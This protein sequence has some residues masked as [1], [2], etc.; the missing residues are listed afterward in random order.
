MER[1]GFGIEVEDQ[2]RLNV[3]II[4]SISDLALA[5]SR[6]VSALSYAEKIE[7]L[8]NMMEEM[9][10]KSRDNSSILFTMLQD[11]EKKFEK[12]INEVK[13]ELV[14]KIDEVKA[15]GSLSEQPSIALPLAAYGSEKVVPLPGFVIKTRKLLGNK[16][17][18]FI[19]VF[20]HDHVE[21]EPG[22]IP[23]GKANDK[24]Y[25]IACD[26]A[27]STTDK[28]GLVSLLYN[29]VVSAEY[30]KQPNDH[31]EMK[32]TSPASIQKVRQKTYLSCLL[33][34]YFHKQ[35]LTLFHFFGFDSKT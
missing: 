22:T 16:E 18:A 15:R 28:E 27:S 8:I 10:I 12:R 13:V 21:F 9:H 17:K 31:P 7:N 19:N 25:F 20:Y 14:A 5:E 2:S 30:F 11:F 4:N 3:D 26:E 1:G 33:F 34:F 24:P 29:I 6:D 32:I 35:R 23:K